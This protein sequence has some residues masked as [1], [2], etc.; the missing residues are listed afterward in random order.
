MKHLIIEISYVC[1]ILFSL[2]TEYWFSINNYFLSIFIWPGKYI[3]IQIKQV[4]VK[5]DLPF[6]LNTFSIKKCILVIWAIS[7]Y[8]MKSVNIIVLGNQILMVMICLVLLLWRKENTYVSMKPWRKS[9]T[10][11]LTLKKKN[12]EIFR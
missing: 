9:S 2:L 8:F 4:I 11:W 12:L 3:Y 7:Q 10:C 6:L 5:R 1:S